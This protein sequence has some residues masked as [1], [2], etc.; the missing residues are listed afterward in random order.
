MPFI[1]ISAPGLSAYMTGSTTFSIGDVG[2]SN[3]RNSPGPRF[4]IYGWATTADAL[5]FG[6]R[7]AATTVTGL[8]NS[9][10]CP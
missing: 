3:I 6:L 5:E 2:D 7:S 8:P 10:T 1:T 9:W 4:D